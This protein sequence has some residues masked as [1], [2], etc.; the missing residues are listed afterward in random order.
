MV[1]NARP[2]HTL[3]LGLASLLGLLA[4][5]CGNPLPGTV[6]GT[7]QV[8]A[9]AQANSCG[10]GLGAPSV[11]QFDVQLSETTATPTLYWDWLDSTPIASGPLTAV[12]STDASLTA[13]MTASQSS[14][15]DATA[16]A[17]GP[18]TM[19]RDDTM[20]VTLGTG[21]PPSTFA[22]TMSYAFTVESGAIC[23]DQLSSAGGMYDE[24]PCTLSYTIAGTVQ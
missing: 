24:L 22:G 4:S 20:V 3:S 18:C 15:V 2:S 12:S 7:Y 1:P 8:T 17:A 13:T 5:G 19:D 9:T 10:T 11:Y 16:T 21:T 6:L 23:S 14:N